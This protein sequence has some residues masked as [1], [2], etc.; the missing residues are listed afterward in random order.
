[1]AVDWNAVGAISTAGAAVIALA[2]WVSDLI[3]RHRERRATER[4]LA[5]V[6]IP[7]V[8]TA[9]LEIAKLRTYL[10]EPCDGEMTRAHFLFRSG[11][12]R[13]EAAERAARVVL[14]LPPAVVDRA[15]AFRPRASNRMAW[16]AAKVR[17]LNDASRLMMEI[18]P[19][20]S[21][22][23]LDTAITVF[24]TEVLETE[25]AIG[26]AFEILLVAGKA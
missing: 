1:M 22:E 9:Q 3:H 25:K 18:G 12:A 4:F 10:A 8:A 5:Q 20:I 15:A 16:A 19:G 17:R 23:G 14:D 6:T 21:K 2:I 26:E 24:C 13:A 7:A 11:D